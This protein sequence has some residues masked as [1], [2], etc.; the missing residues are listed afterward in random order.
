MTWAFVWYIISFSL[1]LFSSFF[2]KSFMSVQLNILKLMSKETFV[3][4]PV[5][6]YENSFTLLANSISVAAAPGTIRLSR[7]IA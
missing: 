3:N 6:L 7:H 4:Y 5:S 2:P 1:V